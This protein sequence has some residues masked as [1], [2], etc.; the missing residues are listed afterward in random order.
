MIGQL[1]RHTPVI[2]QGATG[3]TGSVH[4]RRMKEYGT[5]IVAGVLGARRRGQRRRRSGVFRLPRGG[6]GDRRKGF[7]CDGAAQRRAGARR[8]TPSAPAS[9]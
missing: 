5:N 2:V 4:V 8:K 3:R 6:C 9:S 1:S 7:A